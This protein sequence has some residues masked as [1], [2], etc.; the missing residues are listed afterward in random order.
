MISKH[1]SYY[2]CHK[3]L[4][5]CEYCYCPLYPCKDEV[6]GKWII[7]RKMNKIWD[8]SECIRFHG[9]DSEDKMKEYKKEK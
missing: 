1:C 5:D 9:K 8:C 3:G 6:W 7:D 2:P 4:E